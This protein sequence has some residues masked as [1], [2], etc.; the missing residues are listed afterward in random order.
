MLVALLTMGSLLVIANPAVSADE[1]LPSWRA[2]DT[3][4]R[5]V[6]FVG[7]ATETGGPA[8]IAPSDRVAV[9]DNDGTLWSE[10]PVYFQ[11]LFAIDRA[12][13][14]LR[15]D[16]ALA[17]QSPFKE[18]A[19][20]GA[21][22]LSEG[23]E[24]LLLSLVAHTHTG[25]TETAFSEAVKEWT[26][27]ARHPVTGQ[28]YTAMVY[29]PMLELLDY[30][31]DN[32]FQVW[33]VSGGTVSFM[34]A[35]AEEVYGIPPE[36]IIGTRFALEYKDGELLRQAKIAH[37][38]DKG[39]KPIGIQQQIGRRPVLAVGNSDGDFQMLEWTTLSDGPSLGLLVHH[40]DAE[41]EWAY[42]RESTVGRLDRGLKEA[43]TRGWQLIDVQKDW[44]KIY[45]WST[46]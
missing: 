44:D 31:R 24:E 8:Y 23:G 7:D 25:I 22:A 43:K 20:G 30:L 32:D 3:R 19:S 39:G 37:N 18:L 11:V 14:M 17:A 46:D 5:I 15:A 13:A 40:T 34:R 35:W 4:E 10:Q 26:E 45:P 6:S 29:Q 33:I 16:P 42:D 12:K 28:P 36:N 2:T 41:R 21:P 1:P 27:N 38:N 9:F